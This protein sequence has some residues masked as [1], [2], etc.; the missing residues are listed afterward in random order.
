MSLKYDTSNDDKDFEIAFDAITKD[1]VN[2]LF[3][4]YDI[5]WG[6]YACMQ[7]YSSKLDS[8][9]R[10]SHTNSN[11]ETQKQACDD[12]SG[13]WMTEKID[14]SSSPFHGWTDLELFGPDLRD[15]NRDDSCWAYFDEQGEWRIGG[16][17]YNFQIVNENGYNDQLRLFLWKDIAVPESDA[18]YLGSQVQVR[19]D[20]NT[21]LF[22]FFCSDENVGGTAL[23]YKDQT[24]DF[25]HIACPI[26]R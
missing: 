4:H 14:D 17:F 24:G 6:Q 13:I 26:Y 2:S 22:T 19:V 23:T 1:T 21:M 11:S 7:P 16:S 25:D 18:C 20:E 12:L 10:S 15:N 9:S 3:D 8:S 5:K